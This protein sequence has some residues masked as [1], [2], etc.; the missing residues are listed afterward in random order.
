M[1]LSKVT[2][3]VSIQ[4]CSMGP[5]PAQSCQH[6]PRGIFGRD[7]PTET[8]R[9]GRGSQ[10]GWTRWTRAPQY[11]NPRRNK[12]G[13]FLGSKQGRIFS[14]GRIF[15]KI[16]KILSTFFLGRP[17]WFSEL[18]QSST[19]TLFWP[20]F[21]RNRQSFEKTGQKRRF[22]HFWKILTKNCVFSA[23]PS[24]PPQN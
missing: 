20:N 6:L 18:Y 15:K 21:L 1:T 12:T 11:H 22:R 5:S 3:H 14:R 8:T 9:R 23:P 10:S 19:K 13:R 17:N 24:P 16:S 4:W 7:T 2:P